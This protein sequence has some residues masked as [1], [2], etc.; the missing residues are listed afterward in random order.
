MIWF[1]HASGGL[2]LATGAASVARMTAD[3][4]HFAADELLIEHLA[5]N[6]SR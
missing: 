3:A 6:G 4:K 2:A 1:W 5:Y